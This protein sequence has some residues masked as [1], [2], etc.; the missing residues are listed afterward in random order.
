MT[1]VRQPT[2]EE[3][4]AIH[5]RFIHAIDEIVISIQNDQ[6]ELD[7]ADVCECIARVLAAASASMAA[8]AGYCEHDFA[9]CTDEA[10]KFASEPINQ[11]QPS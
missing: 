11:E 10:Y 1:A 8:G 4:F 5:D 2:R 3:M 6:P 9:K 7:A